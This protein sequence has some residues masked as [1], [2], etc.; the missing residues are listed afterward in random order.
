MRAQYA[1]MVADSTPG[2]FE[3][4]HPMT[5]YVYE[6]LMNGD[7]GD[8]E[9]GDSDFGWAVRYGRRVLWGTSTGFI[10]LSTYPTATAAASDLD[11]AMPYD[12]DD[13]E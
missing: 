5:A 13:D 4:E 10:S 1:E 7:T 12:D 6:L 9:C 2:R 3:G 11:A 8:E